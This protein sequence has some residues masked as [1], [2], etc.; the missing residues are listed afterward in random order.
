MYARTHT[1]TQNIPAD[2]RV[3]NLNEK[4]QAFTHW[5]NM[6]YTLILTTTYKNPYFFSLLSLAFYLRRRTDVK[7][8][9]Y[10]YSAILLSIF[11]FACR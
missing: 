3:Y 1:H 6:E 5:R 10:L 11:F 9:I 7:V 8:K 2:I 4:R